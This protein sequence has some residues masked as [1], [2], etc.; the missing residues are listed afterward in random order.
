MNMI[1]ILMVLWILLYI[2]KISDKQFND[3]NIFLYN[4]DFLNNKALN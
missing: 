3:D 1:K 2:G 4:Y